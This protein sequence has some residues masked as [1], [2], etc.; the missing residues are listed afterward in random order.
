MRLQSLLAILLLVAPSA[1][2]AEVTM[3]FDPVTW[4]PGATDKVFFHVVNHTQ[5]HMIGVDFI[6]Y[7]PASLEFQGMGVS[8][9]NWTIQ[10]VL[11]DTITGFIG[12]TID[13]Q[14]PPR[15]DGSIAYTNSGNSIAFCNPHIRAV[16]LRA[17]YPQGDFTTE[18]TSLCSPT[19]VLD[20]RAPFRAWGAI[21]ELYR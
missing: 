15:L 8:I 14:A 1:R 19:D 16:R 6:V 11:A 4:G 12:Y 7:H 13:L 20:D 21:K 10:P 2:A 18:I 9:P 5:E 3:T 17:G